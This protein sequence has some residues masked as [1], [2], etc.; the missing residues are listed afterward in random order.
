MI[1]LIPCVSYFHVSVKVSLASPPTSLPPTHL[2]LVSLECQ[3]RDKMEFMDAEPRIRP[4]SPDE[5]DAQRSN[6]VVASL[7]CGIFDVF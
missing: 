1:L 7:D 4:P 5:Y 6:G 3:M 2:P